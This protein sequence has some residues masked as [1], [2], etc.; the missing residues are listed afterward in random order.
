MMAA[1]MGQRYRS[2]KLNTG[3]AAEGLTF[4]R[5]LFL[6]LFHADDPGDQ[7]AGGN[8]RNGHHHRVGQEVE[9]IEELHPEHGHA[10]K[11]AVAQR[12]TGCPA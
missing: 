11:G 5:D 9:E 1:K 12:G 10:G 8:G 6:D 3:L 4:L 2:I 7:Q